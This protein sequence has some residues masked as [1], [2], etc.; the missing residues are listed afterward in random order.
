MLRILQSTAKFDHFLPFSLKIPK[1]FVVNCKIE[2]LFCA[3]LYKLETTLLFTS[4]FMYFKLLFASLFTDFFSFFGKKYK[5][6]WWWDKKNCKVDSKHIIYEVT[7]E[8]KKCYEC[9]ILAWI[10]LSILHMIWVWAEYDPLKGENIEYEGS[11][12]LKEKL[13]L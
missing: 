2:A 6:I 12:L 4:K 11:L 10:V 7:E 3:L 8:V 5:Y 1:N 9:A 13:Q